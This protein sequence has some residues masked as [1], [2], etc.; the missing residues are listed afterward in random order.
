MFKMDLDGRSASLGSLYS[1]YSNEFFGGVSFWNTSVIDEQKD[2]LLQ[3]SS[4][5]G[6][7]QR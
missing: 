4:K 6:E 7:D 3:T 1:A 5:L 2:V